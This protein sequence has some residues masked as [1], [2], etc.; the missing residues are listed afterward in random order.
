MHAL[1]A[2]TATLAIAGPP[3]AGVLAPGRSLGGLRLGM[4][5]AQV[6][7][8]WGTRH[9]RC[10]DCAQTTW[11]FTFKRFEPQG[12]GVAF[13]RGRVAAIFTLWSP[14]GWRTSRGL[15]IGESAARVGTVYG[16]LLEVQCGTY[17]ALVLP[18]PRVKTLFYVYDEKVWGFGLSSAAAPACH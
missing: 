2:L 4:T 5:P 8:A 17:S 15:A 7:T 12:A 14:S 16:G 18:G 1:A 11:Y 10:R 3:Q 6:E 13:E 9:G